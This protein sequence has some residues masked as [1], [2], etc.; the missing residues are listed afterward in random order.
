MEIVRVAFERQLLPD[1]V[2]TST[3]FFRFDTDCVEAAKAH[4]E[5]IARKHPLDAAGWKSK[6]AVV[7]EAQFRQEVACD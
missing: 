4:G 5:N 2:S 3:A 7:T 6:V 1:L